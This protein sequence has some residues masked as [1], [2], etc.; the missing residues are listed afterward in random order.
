VRAVKTWS[1]PPGK[2][3]T[4]T[5]PCALCGGKVFNPAL[6]CEGF[7][8]VRCENCGLVQ[9]NPQ[10]EHT[11]VRRR[12]QDG[13]G[14]DYL[15]YELANEVSF[16][17]LQQLALADAGM[18]ELERVLK[19]EKSGAPGV[20]DIGCATGALLAEFRD[21]GW[22]TCGAE[23][24]GPQAEYARRERGLDI[25]D[26]PLEEN[27]F[28]DGEFDLVL[29]SHLIEHLNDP[30]SFVKEA[31]RILAPGGRF[32][33]TTPNIDGLQSR[34][35]KGRWR[36]AI[37]DH[38]YLF[39]IKTLSALLEKTGFRIE[40]TVTWGGLAAGLGPRWIKGPADKLAKKLGFG[41]V[42]L[43]RAL[44][45]KTPDP[46]LAEIVLRIPK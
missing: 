42:M 25:R 7:A 28:S 37:F 9:M 13:Y 34:L 5:V 12:Y 46:A 19:S 22:K 41:D 43:I 35:L 17:R 21:R 31:F 32:M 36:S 20:L 29:A 26:R 15:A 6:R 1:T 33:V 38:L 10:P 2:E 39:S 24:G 23:I 45:V 3:K 8:Y 11:D 40:R 18:E 27:Q 4:K 14:S 16:L 30:A 44:V